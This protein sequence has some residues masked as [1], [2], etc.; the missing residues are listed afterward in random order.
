V[1]LK[2]SVDG[3]P[4]GMSRL[5]NLVINHGDNNIEMASTVNQTLMLRAVAGPDAKYT[6]GI[7]P[8]D[9]VGNSSVYN[10][11]DL[12]YFSKALAANK[13]K[14]DLNIFAASSDQSG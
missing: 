1:T 9:I 7:V 14:L 2:L 13:L 11:Q 5:Q 10:G 3:I 4:V 8:V 12:P 6:D